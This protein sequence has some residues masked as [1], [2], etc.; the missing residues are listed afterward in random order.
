MPRTSYTAPSKDTVRTRHTPGPRL[1]IK[2]PERCPS[3]NSTK[4]A[5]KGTRAK[6]LET[7]RL[8][9]CRTCGRTFMPGPRAVR[10]K[11]YPLNE[12]LDAFT[13]Y[14]RG[15]SLEDTSRRLS[16]RYGHAVNPATISRWLA[17]HPG[18][19][20]YRRLRARGLRLF[21]PPQI[22]RTI[23]LYHRQVYEFAYHR[24]KLAFLRNGTL[25]DR[26]SGDTRFAPLAD[27][28]DR[29]AHTRPDELF[30]RED[31][32]RS[33]QLPSGFLELDRLTVF[34]KQNIATDTAALIIPSVGSNH[35]RH[36]KLQRF[37]LANDSATL[38]VE[39]PIWLIEDDIAAL[40]DRYGVAIVTKE[41]IHPA[42]P[43]RGH[44]PRFI[45]G[46]IDF[47]QVRNG[48]IHVLDY[49]PDARTNKPI[50]Q[51]TIYALAL[52]R[53]VPGLRLFDIKTAWFNETCYNEF[54][55]RLVLPR[56]KSFHQMVR[57]IHEEEAEERNRLR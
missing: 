12:I 20:T 47:L 51:L 32:A 44:K 50:A 52:T 21:K 46:H 10:N 55:P 30:Q 40:E 1:A 11:T 38:A 37:M 3:C 18:L 45:T 28:L 26:R 17:A 6:K 33:S 43:S 25:D 19:T 56:P 48:A 5:P 57:E 24:A 13:I 53:L 8:Y 29:L 42:R 27:F 31:G 14:N 34:E 35:D 54:L 39:V 49:K 4:V 7:V 9:R 2:S 23:K 15:N 41:P 36:P 16:S 22:I